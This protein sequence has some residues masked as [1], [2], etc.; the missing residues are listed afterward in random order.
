LVQQKQASPIASNRALHQAYTKL[1]CPNVPK[2]SEWHLKIH[3]Y[4]AMIFHLC[5]P[6]IDIIILQ[7]V[8]KSLKFDSQ[9]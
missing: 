4:R 9:T 6:G 1:A 2:L 3:E 8:E 7:L 5:K